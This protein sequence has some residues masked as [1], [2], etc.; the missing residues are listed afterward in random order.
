LQEANTDVDVSPAF[1]R[2]STLAWQ[3]EYPPERLQHQTARHD[4]KLDRFDKL[5]N[6]GPWVFSKKC[7][8]KKGNGNQNLNR[9]AHGANLPL[10]SPLG[11]RLKVTPLLSAEVS[12]Q[13]AKQTSLRRAPLSCIPVIRGRNDRVAL[14]H[15]VILTNLPSR[16][17]P[18]GPLR[19][20]KTV[21]PIIAPFLAA[22]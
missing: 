16:P 7:E 3:S 12:S 17:G 8:K 9:A 21:E 20:V 5:K 14:R 4:S 15:G 2:T 19:R 13:Y 1:V 18:S 6:T 22:M 11:K 10:S